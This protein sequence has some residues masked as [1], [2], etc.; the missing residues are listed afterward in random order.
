VEELGVGPMPLW[1]DRFARTLHG[2]RDAVRHAGV[3]TGT[4]LGNPGFFNNGKPKWMVSFTDNP[5]KM[6]GH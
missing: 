1:I 4:V 2:G 3:G 5:T 6:G